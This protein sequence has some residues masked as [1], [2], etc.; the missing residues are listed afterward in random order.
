MTPD[1]ALPIR[2]RRSPRAR[3]I[4]LRIDPVRGDAEL[5]LPLSARRAEGERF[6]ARHHAWVTRQIAA[7]PPRRPFIDGARLSVLG[8]EIVIAHRRAERRPA[9]LDA[10]AL[11]VGGAADCL[12]ARV[13]VWLRAT[14]R[15]ALHDAVSRHAEML[16][17]PF[18][19]LR[20][21]D[22]RSRWGSCSPR[23]VL[24]FSWRL[25]LAPVRVLDYVERLD[26]DYPAARAWLVRHG[27]G[28]HRYGG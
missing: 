10:G 20:I 3:R 8:R 7:L 5:V 26:P 15:S 2:T 19:A 21:G 17:T 22:P 9:R 11:I 1:R 12:S 24:S 25:V 27:P 16:D 6:V 18:S 4:R 14:A 13:A 28:L 23:G